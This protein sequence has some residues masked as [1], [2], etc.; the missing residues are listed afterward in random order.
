MTRLIA[1]TGPDGTGKSTL[2]NAVVEALDAR[3]TSARV[4]QIWDALGDL[5]RRGEAQTY[6]RELDHL[7]RGTL[8]LHGLARSLQ[9]GM[10]SGA[11]VVVLDGYWYKYAVSERAHGGPAA[12]FDACPTLF[13]VPEH[14]FVLRVPDEVARTRK[15]E[16]TAYERGHSEAEAA[17]ARFQAKMTPLWAEI[18]RAHGPWT[19]LDGTAPPEDNA[20]RIV[21]RLTGRG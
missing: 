4:V 5:L 11:E 2:A 16:S 14:T 13:P 18:E 17:F 20:A 8:L 15:T 12:L 7:G 21:E 3:N 1:L 6:L 10:A 19:A 9:L